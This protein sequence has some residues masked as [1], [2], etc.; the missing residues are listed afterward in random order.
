MAAKPIQKPRRAMLDANE[1]SILCEQIALV[2]RSGLPLHDGVEALCESYRHTRLGDRFEAFNNAV[3]ASGSLYGGIIAADI[4]PPYMA[5]MT[6][7]GERTG[8]LDNVMAGLSQYYQREAKIRRAVVNAVTYPLI[9]IAMMATLII[10]LITQVLPIF[11]NVFQGMGVDATANPW[12]GAGIGIGKAVLILAGILIIVLF[13][14]LTALRLDRTGRVRMLINRCIPPVRKIGVKIS[15]GRFTSVMAMMLKSGF[16]LNESLRL[17]GGVVGNPDIASKIQACREQM[18]NG[19]SFPD[20]LDTLQLFTPLHSRM[21]RL[22][23]QTGQTEAV[24]RKL[25]A[26]YEDEVDDAITHFVSI[27]EPTLVAL[28]SVIIGAVLLA[29]M[30]PL[31]SLLGGMA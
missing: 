3:L 30:L 2:I 19:L 10:L 24:M 15:A 13:V 18:D 31:L 20:A 26:L 23:F 5:E 14:L 6:Q 29:V 22:S 1:L 25:A 16:P 12:L 11:E 9:L 17:V 28:M 4:F 8:E 21:I 27:I 7:I